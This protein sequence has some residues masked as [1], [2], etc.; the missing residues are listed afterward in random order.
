MTI[1]PPR[2][3]DLP[4]P[5]PGRTGFPWT[6]ETP[7][8]PVDLPAPRITVVTPSY[9]QGQYLEETIRSVLLQG[10]PN[11]EYIVIDGNSPDNSVEIIK[12]YAP[13]LYYWVSEPDSGQTNAINK[14]FARSTG[15]IMGW[16]NSD[17]L[18]L[19]GAL[20]RIARAFVDNP[21]LELVTGFRKNIDEHS[22]VTSN[23]VR[24]PPTIYYMRHYCCVAQET[25]YWRRSLWE[26]LGSLDESLHFAMDYE[27]WL[28]AIQHGRS[29]H[30]LPSYIGGFRDYAQNK[31]SSWRDVYEHDT[32]IIYHRY[33]M[34]KN[35]ADVHAKLGHRWSRRYGFY[36]A[37]G[38][39]TWT[40][41]PQLVQI[42]RSILEVPILCDIIL[43]SWQFYNKYQEL[44]QTYHLAQLD[45][46]RKSVR[47]AFEYIVRSYQHQRASAE[48]ATLPWGSVD[49]VPRLS[50]IAGIED[51]LPEDT[52][53]FG[54][55]WYP[56]EF[57]AGK[58][59]C[60]STSVSEISR[61]N[62]SSAQHTIQ[63]TIS[64][65]VPAPGNQIDIYDEAGSKLASAAGD[66][67][68]VEITFESP[69][70]QNRQVKYTL[71]WQGETAAPNDNDRRSLAFRILSLGWRDA[72][73]ELE[74]AD[75][76]FQ[77]AVED[78][79][80]GRSA[81]KIPLPGIVTTVLQRWQTAPNVMASQLALWQQLNEAQRRASAQRPEMRLGL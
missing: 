22:R 73:T 51:R 65:A 2:L 28:R 27:Y 41:S 47:F 37:L 61:L 17:D 18:L 34:G 21:Q 45:A 7:A 9:K 12:K 32:N 19:P 69:P 31:S 67:D 26:A 46:L 62:A 55:G 4:A 6:E 23:F 54:T 35:E 38:K 24:D 71:R 81:T 80:T 74:L 44:R 13:W 77:R 16:L 39:Y 78:S 79:L 52:L 49:T 43:S 72:A 48:S 70:A 58:Y 42:A 33:E 3:Q 66:Q 30:L 59:F 56:L 10:Y 64:P 53:I 75:S 8:L 68:R 50:E 60:W 15:A 63:L 40:N 11:L 14:G 1:T 57:Y 25:T 20:Q 29:F 5:P 36:V 76:A